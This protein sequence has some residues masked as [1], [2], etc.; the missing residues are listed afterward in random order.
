M[1]KRVI[2]ENWGNVLGMFYSASISTY[3]P[4]PHDKDAHLA[5]AE[6]KRQRRLARNQGHGWYGAIPA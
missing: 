6:A 1:K 2:P 4:V 5:R 3:S